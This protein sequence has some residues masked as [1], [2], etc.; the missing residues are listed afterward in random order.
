L[1]QDC[2]LSPTLIP[3]YFDDLE[4]AMLAAA[5]RGAQLDLPW[6]RGSSGMVPPLLKADDTTLLATSPARPAAAV[7]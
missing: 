3:L 4:A 7:L 1:K 6:L 5:Q 2:P